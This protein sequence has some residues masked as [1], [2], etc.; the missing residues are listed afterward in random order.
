MRFVFHLRPDL[1]FRQT[2]PTCQDLY[3][4]DAFA[5]PFAE[6][7]QL[8]SLGCLLQVRLFRW[9]RICGR[10]DVPRLHLILRALNLFGF[11]K[12]HSYFWSRPVGFGSVKFSVFL[13]LHWF[14]C[15]NS[16]FMRLIIFCC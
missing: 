1:H 15:L 13:N 11:L 4:V 16:S 10:Q 6:D 5:L 2:F 14:E 9:R 3:F 8:D 7:D 12:A